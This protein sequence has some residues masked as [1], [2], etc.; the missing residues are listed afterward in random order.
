MENNN[1]EFRTIDFGPYV[2]LAP[3]DISL[4]SETTI[5]KIGKK[6]RADQFIAAIE[7]HNL[8]SQTTPD[9]EDSSVIEHLYCE[10]GP[11]SFRQ[12][13]NLIKGKPGFHYSLLPEKSAW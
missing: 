7:Q 1:E 6:V 4:E 11:I 8:L 5:L 12:K 3:P 9:S 10:R 13:A 2:V